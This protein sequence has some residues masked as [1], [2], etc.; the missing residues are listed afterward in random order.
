MAE[1]LF[2]DHALTADGWARDFRIEITE[3]GH[4]GRLGGDRQ[5]G[6]H[7]VAILLP[8]PGNLH[9][10]TFQ[11]GMAG[12]SEG[13]GPDGRDSFWTWR[14]LMY[15]FLDRLTPDDVEA[16]A[17]LAFMEMLEAGFGS[18]AEFH[19]LHHRPDGG[20]YDNIAEMSDRIVAAASAT[21]I[22][23][24]LLP[25]LYQHGGADKRPVGDGQRRFAC[26]ADRFES[27]H[28]GGVRATSSGN[29]DTRIGIAPH[30]LRAV[31]SD[32][33]TL[34]IGI[35]PDGPIHIHVAEQVAE[36][37]EIKAA[38]GARPVEWLLANQ[39][40]D[41]HWCLIHATQMTAD[42]TLALARSGAI[43]G[44]CPIT[45]SNLGDGIFD[46]ARYLAAGGRFGVGTD[47]NVRISL[48]EELRTLEYSQRLRDRTR[49]VLATEDR[50]TGRVLY[51]GACRGGAQALRRDAGVIE[52]GRLADLV[53][54]DA[55]SIDLA[56]LSGDAILDTL[57]F[58][59][60]GNQITDLWS[61]GRSVVSE[62]RHKDRETIIG[63]ARRAFARLRDAL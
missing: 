7:N 18:V 54:V 57:I 23:L 46:G 52:T 58:A 62:G 42:E 19:Y 29:A 41:R 26:D 55:A 47:S 43:A 53:A 56:G 39:S 44:L 15:R 49:A 33:L 24:T 10:H 35:C 4:I 31:H 51:D 38:W 63:N 17:A 59:G 27:L 40:V 6:D 50:S 20:S 1:S 48:V 45:E 3:D 21:G 14:K 28:A 25:V 60:S 36:V 13:R 34:A 37:D 32:G 8:A 30:S 9:S 11:R 12:L 16:I 5:A 61:A 2:A 22:G